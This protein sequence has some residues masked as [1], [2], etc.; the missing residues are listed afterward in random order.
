[1]GKN[2]NE[3]RARPACP[4]CVFAAAVTAS[5]SLL[6]VSFVQGRPKDF[7][8]DTVPSCSQLVVLYPDP[9]SPHAQRLFSQQRGYF[10]TPRSLCWVY[11]APRL[12]TS[13]KITLLPPFFFFQVC[14]RTDRP[15]NCGLM[16]RW[17]CPGTWAGR[18]GQLRRL[19]GLLVAFGCCL[20]EPESETVKYQDGL[21]QDLFARSNPPNLSSPSFWFCPALASF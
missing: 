1:M 7:H 16:E 18:A 13:L 20:G 3:S 14:S 10:P 4:A 11:P 12:V 15:R 5:I 2:A 9:P 19:R 21:K 8:R 6:F 17:G